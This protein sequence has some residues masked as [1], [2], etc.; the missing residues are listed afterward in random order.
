M[1]LFQ[2]LFLSLKKY[3]EIKISRKVIKIEHIFTS[4]YYVMVYLCYGKIKFLF[5][6]C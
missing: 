3:V 5:D 4:N 1:S 2:R 6:T